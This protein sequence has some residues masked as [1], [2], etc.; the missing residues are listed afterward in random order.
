MVMTLMEANQNSVS[1]NDRTETRFVAVS[2]NINTSEMSHCGTTATKG[3]SNPAPA[4]ASKATT[5]TQ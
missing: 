3:F 5:P 2:S 4:T 1:P